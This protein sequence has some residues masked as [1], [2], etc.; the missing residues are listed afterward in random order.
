MSQLRPRPPA[1]A[2]VQLLV[3][4]EPSLKVRVDRLARKRGIFMTRII[5]DALETYLDGAEERP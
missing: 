4:I 2:T 5:E 1:K 3:R